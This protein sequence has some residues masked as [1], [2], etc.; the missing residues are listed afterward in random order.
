[1]ISSSDVYI[2]ACNE[3]RDFLLCDQFVRT[4]SRKGEL[5]FWIGPEKESFSHPLS[6]NYDVLLNTFRQGIY[7]D[8]D[9]NLERKNLFTHFDSNDLSNE[10]RNLVRKVDNLD[11][12]QK[13]LAVTMFGFASKRDILYL[14][15]SPAEKVGCWL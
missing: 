9:L 10:L 2:K 12:G 3:M 1:M 4:N 5:S 14:G 6:M 11:D 8:Q 15:A 13:K 7:V